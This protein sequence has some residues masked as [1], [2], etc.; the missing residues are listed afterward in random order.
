MRMRISCMLQMSKFDTQI[1]VEETLDE[2]EIEYQS[3]LRQNQ[4]LYNAKKRKPVIDQEPKICPHC[5]DWSTPDE[6]TGGCVFCG[7]PIF[8]MGEI[9]DRIKDMFEE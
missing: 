6:E 7:A 5:R 3:E 4:A 9:A 1:Q 2:D 8:E